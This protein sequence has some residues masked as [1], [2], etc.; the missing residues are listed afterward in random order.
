L[1]DELCLADGRRATVSAARR[2][3]APDDQPFR[4]Y[5]LSVDEGRT[6]FAGR[7]GAWVHNTGG[8]WET[9]CKLVAVQVRD[10]VD[11]APNLTDDAVLQ[12]IEEA[13]KK[14]GDATDADA[15]TRKKHLRDVVEYLTNPNDPDNPA[16]PDGRRER[17]LEAIDERFTAPVAGV[18]GEIIAKASEALAP[19]KAAFPDAKVGFRGS[20]AR[21]TKGAHKGNAPFDPSNYDVD[22]F[23]VSD[24]MAAKIPKVS[25]GFRNLGR[26]PEHRKLIESISNKLRTIAGHR[27]EAVKIRVFSHEEFKKLAADEVHLLQ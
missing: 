25:K 15:F 22:A 4:T 21:G 20:L 12:L 14:H 19:L 17:L 8:A 23:I 16:L 6:Y 10:Q 9:T 18:R 26:L 7:L 13:I 27:D 5:N 3:D 1:G 11:A 2:E 24:S